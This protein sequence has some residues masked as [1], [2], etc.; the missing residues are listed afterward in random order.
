M[1]DDVSEVEESV[2][3]SR[4]K[5]E[6]SIDRLQSRLTPSSVIDDALGAVRDSDY[7]PL[8][9]DAFAALRSNPVPV[10]LAAAA[11]GWFAY[12][13]NRKTQER[14]ALERQALA[15]YEPAA[16][17]KLHQEPMSIEPAARTSG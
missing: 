15:A 9:D 6:Q 13:V 4:A 17:S 8:I 12:E 16:D 10:A 3:R 7:A 1:S 2:A 14:R 11:I 5:L